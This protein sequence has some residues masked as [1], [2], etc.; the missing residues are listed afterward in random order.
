[1]PGVGEGVD[2]DDVVVGWAS[3]VWWTK[4]AP[5]NPAPP[6]TMTLMAPM[7]KAPHYDHLS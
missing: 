6:V 5:M 4:L 3:T 2:H 1:M 7:L